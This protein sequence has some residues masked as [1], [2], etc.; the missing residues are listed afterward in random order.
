MGW[1]DFLNNNPI[2]Q[3]FSKVASSAVDHVDKKVQSGFDKVEKKI[4]SF[5]R[6]GQALGG[7]IDNIGITVKSTI[8]Y[9]V[10]R[11]HIDEIVENK[12]V[13]DETLPKYIKESS[14]YKSVSKVVDIAGKITKTV[15]KVNDFKK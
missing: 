2:G 15:D 4:D 13:L 14:H 12:K 10:D 5:D 9:G 7:A 8:T 11:N 1:Y 3:T 6:K